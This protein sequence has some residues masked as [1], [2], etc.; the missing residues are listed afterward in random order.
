MLLFG[1]FG[2]GRFV[3]FFLCGRVLQFIVAFSC[4]LR[5]LLFSFCLVGFFKVFLSRLCGR[6]FDW[7]LRGYLHHSF[8]VKVIKDF[9]VVF[10]A[11]ELN[12]TVLQGGK[13]V[14]TRFLYI[15]LAMFFAPL[16]YFLSIKQIDKIKY[17][18]QLLKSLLKCRNITLLILVEALSVQML[19]A[20]QYRKQIIVKFVKIKPHKYFGKNRFFSLAQARQNIIQISMKVIIAWSDSSIYFVCYCLTKYSKILN[21][22]YSTHE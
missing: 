3:R 8:F 7:R 4:C 15:D 11:F 16:D 18:T 13:A 22:M 14:G 9:P 12:V 21:Q 17:S 6:F 19:I 10:S 2:L 5:G 20:Q 1:F